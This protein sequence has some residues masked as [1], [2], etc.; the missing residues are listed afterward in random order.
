MHSYKIIKRRKGNSHVF[1]VVDFPIALL[2]IPICIC[3]I[4][5]KA[6][7]LALLAS[8]KPEMR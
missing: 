1:D 7:C 3:K 8:L 5:D 2:V 4:D 6:D